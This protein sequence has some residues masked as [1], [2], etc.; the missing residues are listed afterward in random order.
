[1]TA[2]GTPP[3]RRVPTRVLARIQR[4]ALGALMSIVVTLLERRMR[5][6]LNRRTRTDSGAPKHRELT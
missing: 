4:A 3:R 5:S 6:A 1:M 2:T